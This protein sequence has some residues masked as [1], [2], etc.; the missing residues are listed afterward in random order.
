MKT[1]NVP[2]SVSWSKVFNL[3]KKVT[4]GLLAWV[5]FSSIF[6]VLPVFL[7]ARGYVTGVLAYEEFEWLVKTVI[8]FFYAA[9]F[10][11]VLMLVRYL[12]RGKS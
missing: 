3:A 7:A 5:A 12:G 1:R 2:V 4:L 8:C 10:T 9:I 11:A 6:F